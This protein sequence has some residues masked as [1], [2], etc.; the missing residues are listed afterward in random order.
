MHCTA[1]AHSVPIRSDPIR[2]DPIQ[3]D[4]ETD[5]QTDRST[6]Y[7]TNL[8]SALRSRIAR[9]SNAMQCKAMKTISYCAVLYL[10]STY[11]HRSS[12]SALVYCTYLYI[13]VVRSTRDY[14][15]ALLIITPPYSITNDLQLSRPI[16]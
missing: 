8:C 1:E 3:S 5:T 9:R 11:P 7:A 2:S 15:H 16:G 6:R 10:T 12:A 13:Q 14:T 4:T